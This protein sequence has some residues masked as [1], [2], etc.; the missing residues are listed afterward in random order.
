MENVENAIFEPPDI[1]IFG[2]NMPPDPPTNL[3]P[4]SLIF[5]SPHLKIRSG[6]RPRQWSPGLPSLCINTHS[7]KALMLNKFGMKSSEYSEKYTFKRNE[8]V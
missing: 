1:K 6:C 8:I 3:A 4:L 7:K 2:G 5:K